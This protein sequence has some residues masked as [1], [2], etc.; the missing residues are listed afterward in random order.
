MR[1]PQLIIPALIFVSLCATG[2]GYFLGFKYWWV[3][4]LL[5]LGLAAMFL[6][7][8]LA[9]FEDDLPGGFNNP[10]GS[11]TPEYVAKV[12][13]VGRGITIGVLVISFTLIAIAFTYFIYSNH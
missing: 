4:L 2:A 7:G 5:P 9:I 3:F 11:N 8:L 13:S 1:R 12:S 6:T 10:D